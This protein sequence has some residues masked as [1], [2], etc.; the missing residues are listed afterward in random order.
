[1]RRKTGRH[2]GIKLFEVRNDAEIAERLAAIEPEL[3][4]REMAKIVR[5]SGSV[6]AK[7]AADNVT[8]DQTGAL[9]RSIGLVLR[10]TPARRRMSVIIGPRKGPQWNLV[11]PKTGRSVRVPIH[12]AHLLEFGVN[13]GM[14]QRKVKRRDGSIDTIMVAHMGFP[15]RPFLTP[16][17]EGSKGAIVSRMEQDFRKMIKKIAGAKR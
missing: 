14:V 12:Y 3:Y 6:I 15:A 11:D 7:A 2:S 9:R 17:Y 13:P 1:M 16:A 4:K 10:K 8:G 5:G